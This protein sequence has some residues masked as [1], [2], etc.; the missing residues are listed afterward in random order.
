MNKSFI[1]NSIT[2][3]NL[4]CGVLSL[5]CT[6]NHDYTT[7]G[8]FILLGGIFDRYD[9]TVARFLNTNS[10]LGKELDS[11]ADLVS[12][13]VAPSL[14]A[15]S[16]YNLKSFGIL[17]LIISLLF[18]VAGAYRLAR[19]NC[20]EF[21]NV[22]TGVPITIAGSLLAILEILSA[23]KLKNI[24][25]VIPMSFM[26]ILAYLMISHLQIKKK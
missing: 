2:L 7:A 24:S 14:L 22:F 15:Y 8:L 9:G 23:V 6:L 12:F 5:Q 3:G 16:L 19:Y 18:P 4:V 1:P 26:L 21:N 20:N 17:G 13:G 25:P 11:L 10:D